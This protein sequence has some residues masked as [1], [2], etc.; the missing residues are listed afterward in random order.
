[1][2]ARLHDYRVLWRAALS[3]TARVDS[4]VVR[5]GA[6]FIAIVVCLA[7]WLDQGL[8]AALV[9]LW[10]LACAMVL[11]IWTWCFIPGAVELGAPANAK[12]VPGM[13]R[14]LVELACM[15]WFAAIAGLAL[16]SL[17]DIGPS[18]PWLLWIMLGTIGS[19]LHAAGHGFGAPLM[20][21]T[22]FGAVVLGQVP[23]TLHAAL[24]PPW[25]AALAL[26]AGAAIVVAAGA[27]FPE[28]GERH[29][30]MIERRLR[31]QPGPGKADPLLQGFGGAR[32][33]RWYAASLRRACA[34][35]DGRGLVLH[36]LGPAHHLGELSAG[37]GALAA[38]LAVIAVFTT[39]HDGADAATGLGWL[40]GSLLLIV[41]M[42][43]T[44]R[45]NGLVAAYPAEQAL[46]R[47]APAMPGTAATFNRH[48]ART[49][50]LQAF[51]AWSLG[52][53]ACLLL[54]VL[55]TG[56]ASTLVR[57]ASI[58]CL[59]LPLV[60]APL[61]NHA[62]RSPLPFLMPM[63]LLAASVAA[64]IAI[65]MAARAVTGVPAMPVA[66]LASIAFA[67]WAVRRG[68]RMV[69]GSPFAFPAGRID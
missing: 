55:G 65:G 35:R 31:L 30:R 6:A 34:R 38:V 25:I 62:M 57:V 53:G 16:S 2:N 49:L 69:D 48:L 5:W 32:V 42:A 19:A 61:R 51:K 68:L 23:A 39:W 60:A 17:A 28:A 26:L 41:P 18:A 52:T 1:M 14:R 10:C 13:R 15:V 40:F 12:L 66:A 29:W 33:K 22:C 21:A 24:S 63:L 37:L 64:S 56:D 43:T 67:A 9:L 45:L 4:A 7:A 36:A 58:C 54:A 50:V 59:T 44:L 11:I 20:V 3:H 47:L 46:V 8:R 27:L